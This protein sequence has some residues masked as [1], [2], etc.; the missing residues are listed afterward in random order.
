[1][2]A[3]QSDT[4]LEAFHRYAAAFRSLNPRAVV[5]CFH[6][7]AFSVFPIGV[8]A[9]ATGAQV[10]ESYRRV[11]AELPSRGYATTEFSRLT[12]RRLGDD[13]AQVSGNGA[14]KT[15]AGEDL[16]RFGLTYLFR[17][18]AGQWKVVVAVIH[19]PLP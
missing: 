18:V 4:A 3:N 19:D 12:E 6:E 11:M 14:W 8:A 10:E 15:A 7:P 2:T 9:L 1:M 16:S 5:P 17:R 13:L